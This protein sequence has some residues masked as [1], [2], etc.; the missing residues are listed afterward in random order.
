MDNPK[1]DK[2]GHKCWYNADGKFHRDDGPAI[3]YAHG[4]KFWFQHGEFHRNDGP[5]IEYANGDTKWCQHDHALSFDKWL[6]KN[7]TL[8]NE[9]KVMMK[10]QY[11]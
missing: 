4:D 1:I 10:L 8:T 11:A 3:E 7:Q 5:A 9:E 6:A 2:Y